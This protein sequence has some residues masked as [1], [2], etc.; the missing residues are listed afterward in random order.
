[1]HPVVHANDENW[2]KYLYF[3]KGRYAHTDTR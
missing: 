1:L 2:R 3:I